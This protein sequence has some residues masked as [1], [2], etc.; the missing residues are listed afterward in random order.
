MRQ[1]ACR[2][3]YCV[4][5]A[6]N[7]RSG[8]R[9]PVAGNQAAGHALSLTLG[10][11]LLVGCR[12][13]DTSRSRI[14]RRHPIEF[15]RRMGAPNSLICLRHHQRGL[16]RPPRCARSVRRYSRRHRHRRALL[17]W[18]RRMV[19]REGRAVLERSFPRLH[20]LRRSHAL[21]VDC[22]VCITHGTVCE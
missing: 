3:R 18:R 14:Q 7:R 12:R 2:R 6:V 16:V 9:Y 1:L 11:R 4:S 10:W 21:R 22:P 19:W 20:E 5:R 8:R 13:H 17:R 15:A